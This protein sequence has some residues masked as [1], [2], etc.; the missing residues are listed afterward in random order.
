MSS[1]N[2]NT[3]GSTA[4]RTS[5]GGNR[6][7]SSKDYTSRFGRPRKTETIS[8]QGLNGSRQNYIVNNYGDYGSSLM[9]G[10]LMGQTSMLWYM[11]FHQAFYYSRPH[12]VT[13]A[14][15]QVEVYPPTFSFGKLLF[16]LMIVGIIVYVIR[17]IYLNKK[18]SSNN[19][20]DSNSRSSFG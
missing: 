4:P 19:V 14:N 3:F 20:Y 5:F 6:L 18:Y 17:Q 16:T 12:Y 10:Y 1:S 11:P 13:N 7:N 15:G 2:R 9:T 8:G